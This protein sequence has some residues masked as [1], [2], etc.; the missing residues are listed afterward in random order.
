VTPNHFCVGLFPE[1]LATGGIQRAGR[2][3][4]AVLAGL[5]ARQG[6]TYQ[7]L[8]LNDPAGEH[9][10]EV[11]EFEFRFTGFHRSKARFLLATR[12]VGHP[13]LIFVAHPNLA[14]VGWL[15]QKRTGARIVVV[16]WGIEVWEPLPV[17]RRWA[18]QAA[19]AVL[20]ISNDT[21]KKAVEIQGVAP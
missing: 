20:A 6:T 14:P 7:F 1:L 8:S 13:R 21:A 12:A 9:R 4:A 5:A 16:T 19:D 18:L 3:M 10:S 15:L 2:H 17:R 11:E